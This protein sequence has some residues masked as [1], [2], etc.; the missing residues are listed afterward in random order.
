MQKTKLENNP[1]ITPVPIVLV[2]T[3]VDGKENYTTVGAFGI[4]CLEP[5][6]YISLKNTHC[7]ARGVRESGF[8][9]VNLPSPDLIQKVDYC[10][11][12]SGNDVDKS[13]LFTSFFD[14][15]GNAPMILE[16]SMNYLCKVREI[17]EIGDF[18]MFFG[19]IIT[20][21]INENYITDG[22]PACHKINPV[23]GMG[24][25]YFSVGDEIGKAFSAGKELMR[26]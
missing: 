1:I 24:M 26:E 25:S 22:N 18:E 2:G 9:S 12:V 15:S 21:Y 5:I 3:M 17:K 11:M 6:F 13:N 8:F 16:C 4:V 7:S 19:D 10:G 20:T 14:E 23:V